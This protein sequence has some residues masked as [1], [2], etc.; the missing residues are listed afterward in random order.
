MHIHPWTGSRVLR[1]SGK[2]LSHDNNQKN[3][4]CI[5][6]KTPKNKGHKEE[7]EDNTHSRV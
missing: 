6:S 7:H 1:H 2:F 5:G 3:L 4:R